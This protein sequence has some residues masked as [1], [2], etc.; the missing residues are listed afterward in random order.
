MITIAPFDDSQ[1]KDRR[2]SVR[3][4][5]TNTSEFDQ[6]RQGTELTLTKHYAQGMVKIHAGFNGQSGDHTVPQMVYGQSQK[7]LLD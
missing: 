4:Q 5:Q 1:Q 6:Y 3:N 7:P 2:R